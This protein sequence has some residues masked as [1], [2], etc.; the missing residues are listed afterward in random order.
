MALQG[1]Q[2]PA[3]LHVPQAQAAVV[4]PRQQGLAVGQHDAA[5]LVAVV[6]VGCAHRS[7]EHR[8]VA[9]EA[10]DEAVGRHL[11]HARHGVD[12]LDLAV[13]EHR[14]AIRHRQRLALVVRHVDEGHAELAVQVL[15]LD[16]HVLAQLLVER[17]ERLVHQ[18]ELRVEHER[19]GQRDALL[20]A[21]RELARQA[22]GHALQ[23]HHVERARDALSLLGF[24]DAA[25]RQRVG[26]VLPDG[27][28]REQRVVLE[29]HA[30]VALVRRGSRDRLAVEHDVAGGRRLEAGEHHQRRRLARARRTEQG[31]E[32]A[33]L[34]VQVE[35]AH[36]EVHAVVGL[37]HAAKTHQRLGGGG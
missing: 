17:A 12:L 25:H 1:G 19:A 21:A 2:A 4:R 7:G 35:L 5:T 28:V 14:D 6:D 13:V 9:D 8:A 34:D 36:D 3:G 15:Q 32:L 23:A 26:D 31:E 22:V 33:A 30:E 37:L 11:V 10:G 24:R 16:L 20:L 27:E 18:H 29:H